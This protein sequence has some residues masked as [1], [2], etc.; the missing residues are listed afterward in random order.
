MVSTNTGVQISALKAKVGILDF[1]C[2]LIFFG[3]EGL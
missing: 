1:Y 2:Y 3:G